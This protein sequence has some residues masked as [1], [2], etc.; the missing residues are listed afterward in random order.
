MSYQRDIAGVETTIMYGWHGNFFLETKTLDHYGQYMPIN[1][2]SFA[3]RTMY[4]TLKYLIHDKIVFT[5]LPTNPSLLIQTLD[6]S[7]V[8]KVK[9]SIRKY[10]RNLSRIKDTLEAFGIE[11]ILVI[12]IQ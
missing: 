1:I 10:L 3:T 9:M 2:D 5:G 6:V 4:H 7:V 8:E 11:I 12:S